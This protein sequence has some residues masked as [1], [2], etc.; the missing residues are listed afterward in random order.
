MGGARAIGRLKQ[1][2]LRG[3]V[4][5]DPGG[6]G[7]WAMLAREFAAQGCCLALCARDGDELAR[8]KAELVQTKANVETFVC[9]LRKQEQV[10]G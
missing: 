3:Q 6:S 7:A 2:N 9:D 5:L 1:D 10:T 8:A 4:V